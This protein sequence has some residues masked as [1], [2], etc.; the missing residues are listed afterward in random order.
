VPI[1]NGG[2]G[3]VTLS[4]CG[5]IGLDPMSASSAP[6][7]Y[8]CARRGSAAERSRRSG[9]GF[10]QALHLPFRPAPAIRGVGAVGIIAAARGAP[11]SAGSDA[12]TL[13][14]LRGDHYWDPRNRLR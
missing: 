9:V 1:A 7:D 13:G 6:Y 11:R 3:A 12:V 5:W 8:P 4:H 10:H 2:V 14:F